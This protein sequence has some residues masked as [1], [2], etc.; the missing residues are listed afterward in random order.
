[1]AV[2][3]TDSV[4]PSL[5]L[6]AGTGIR[7][8]TETLGCA[9]FHGMILLT[10]LHW[11]HWQGLPFFGAGNRDDAEVTLIMPSGLGDPL[12]VCADPWPRRTAPSIRRGYAVDGP[13]R[14][15]I[16]AHT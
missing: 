12:G 8:V 11:D 3:P 2:T 5:L 13:S 10:H 14:S 9:A 4:A 16:Q 1:V 6:D 15:S 7:S